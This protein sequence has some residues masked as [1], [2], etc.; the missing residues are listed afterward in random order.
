M[1]PLKQYQIPERGARIARR[2]GRAYWAYVSDEQRREARGPR[3]VFPNP[4]GWEA[5]CQARKTSQNVERM[6]LDPPPHDSRP[7]NVLQVVLHVEQFQT[8]GSSYGAFDRVQ[9]T[10]AEFEDEQPLRAER[11]RCLRDEPSH[12]L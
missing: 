11:C 12:D 8:R 7:W 2:E 5:G 9:L 1:F 3:R 4:L 10:D 6:T